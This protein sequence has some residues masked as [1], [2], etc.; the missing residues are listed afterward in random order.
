MPQR[1]QNGQI[2]STPCHG[3][4]TF[5]PNMPAITPRGKNMVA[6]AAKMLAAL[7]KRLVKSLS[8]WSTAAWKVSLEI[9][10]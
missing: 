2:A 3:T 7:F 1:A 5:I 6:T 8:A 4:L 10:S 9:Y